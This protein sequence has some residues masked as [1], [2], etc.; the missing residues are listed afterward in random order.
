MKNKDLRAQWKE[1]QWALEETGYRPDD[2]FALAKRLME[3]TM[4]IDLDES[5][6]SKGGDA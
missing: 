2:D 5:W 6:F 4:N 3:D 1:L